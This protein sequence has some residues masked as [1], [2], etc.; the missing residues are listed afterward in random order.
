MKRLPGITCVMLAAAAIVASAPDAMVY[1][2]NRIVSGELW[3]LLTCNWV[4]FSNSHFA[5]NLLAFG[6]AGSL[7]ESQR[8]PGLGYLCLF[9]P[10][11]IGLSVFLT[12][13]D[14]QIFGGLS[15]VATGAMVLLSLHGFREDKGRGWLYLLVLMGIAVK[16]GFEFITGNLVFAES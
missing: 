6:L 14:L 10:V 5:Y 7:I 16:I 15:G 1:D 13:P 12:Q 11:L 8:Y 2:R 9:S 3:R 4:H